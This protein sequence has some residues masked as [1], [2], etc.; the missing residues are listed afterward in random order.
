MGFCS[1]RSSPA[2]PR[3]QSGRLA[4]TNARGSGCSIR[5][6]KWR[7]G[8]Q[9]RDH[10]L[11]RF[12]SMTCPP[13]RSSPATCCRSLCARR[14]CRARP[15]SG[16]NTRRS[17]RR[18]CG[19]SPSMTGRVRHGGN[20]AWSVARARRARRRARP[21]AYITPIDELARRVAKR[22]GTCPDIEASGVPGAAHPR[23][24][25]R[26][27]VGARPAAGTDPRRH[28]PGHRLPGRSLRHLH[29]RRLRR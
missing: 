5:C 21:G 16:P 17:A 20:E 13:R 28:G 19:L 3:G 7:S 1:R 9:R 12:I 22:R 15:R 18:A 8:S 25:A 4:R 26:P 29:G 6:S 24:H 27:G 11:I 14:D 2:G 10:L 23:P